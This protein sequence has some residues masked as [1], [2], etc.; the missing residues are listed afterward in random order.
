MTTW[1]YPAVTFFNKNLMD[2][3]GM[4]YPYQAVM[5]GKWTFDMLCELGM[6]VSEDL[7]GDGKL[8]G[9][10]LYGW[11]TSDGMLRCMPTSFDFP[12]CVVNDGVPE[13]SV[14][15]EKYY[16]VYDRVYNVLW[17][18]DWATVLN[19]SDDDGRTTCFH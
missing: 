10:D 6:R 14:G 2:R 18:N 19:G 1:E 5:D 15:S 4:E 12:L 8:D 17:E 16:D 11:I 3:Y 7:N 13:L 9:E